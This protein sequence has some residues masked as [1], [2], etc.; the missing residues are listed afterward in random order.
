MPDWETIELLVTVKAYPV[1]SDQHGECVCV[2]GIRTDT[3]VPS[4]ARL[5]PVPFR[6]LDSRQRFKKYDIIRL[7]AR[8]TSADTRPESYRPD[9]NS[10]RILRHL[11]TERDWSAR[12]PYVDP[13]RAPSMCAIQSFQA[14][15]GTSLGVFRPRR[16]LDLVWE[17]A[18]PRSARQQAK[19]D[20]G[21]LFDSPSVEGLEEIPYKFRYRYQC[22]DCTGS[23]SHQQRVLDWEIGQAYRSWRGKYGEAGALR[24]IRKKWFVEMCSAAK[25]LH[26]YVGNIARF[27]Q[28]FCVLGC[29]YPPLRTRTAPMF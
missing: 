28:S 7:R 20:Q 18:P 26:F 27:P 15:S 25:D 10:I 22:D 12:R 21:S 4:W 24:A 11:G 1:V 3:P 19:L 29:F 2:A 17:N 9:A 5:F 13:L 14:E 16:V 8:R 6:A 23:G